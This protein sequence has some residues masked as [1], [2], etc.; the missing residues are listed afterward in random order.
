MRNNLSFFAPGKLYLAGEYAVTQPN[1]LAIIMPVKKGIKVTIE[2]QKQSAIVNRQ[3]PLENLVFNFIEEIKN[4]YLRLAIEVVRQLSMSKGMT[5]KPFKLTIESTL[6]ADHGKYGLGS[7]GAIT[8]AVIGALLNFYRIAFTPLMLYQ[9]AVIAT[10]QNYPETSFGDLACSSFN[11]PILYRKFSPKMA[12][13]LKTLHVDKLLNLPWEDLMIEPIHFKIKK[14]IVVYTGTSA[15]SHDMVRKV[16]PF[17]NKNWVEKSNKLVKALTENHQMNIIEDLQ[18]HLLALEKQSQAG[19]I[20][21]NMN[22]IMQIAK[23][24]GGFAKMSGAGGGDCM[25]VFMTK[26]KQVWFTKQM[27]LLNFK[28]LSD[29]I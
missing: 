17:I 23:A 10:I 18:D 22:K 21:N 28:I 29:I 12:T 9:L 4:P 8:V 5:W 16:Q 24:G 3:Y 7:S 1:G 2:S 14:P 26:S 11:Q 6:V 27:K 13:L 20:T 25:L 19:M 15:N